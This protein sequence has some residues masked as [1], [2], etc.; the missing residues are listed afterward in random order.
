MVWSNTPPRIRRR[1]LRR[2]QPPARCSLPLGGGTTKA[3][4]AGVILS[5]CHMG[6]KKRA[7]STPIIELFR[8]TTFAHVWNEYVEFL[9]VRPNLTKGEYLA[10][11]LLP[12]FGRPRPLPN[13]KFQR[14]LD[15]KAT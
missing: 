1:T 8:A 15:G 3:N 10:R 11:Q 14:H 4:R 9:G 5:A 7:R 6:T 13:Y 2:V 12:P